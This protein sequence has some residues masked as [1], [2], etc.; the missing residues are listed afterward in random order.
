MTRDYAAISRYNEEQLGKDRKSRMSQVA[1]Y[2]DT[3]HFVYELLQN[4]DDAGATEIDFLLRPNQLIV[5]HNGTPFTEENVRAISYFGKGKTDVTAIGRFG[6]GFKSVFA[7]TATPSIHSV[8]DDFELVDL[9]TLKPAA[10]PKDL[11]S[12]RTR[13]VLPFDHPEKKPIYIEPGMLKSPVLAYGEIA[14]KLR[15]LGGATLLFTSHLR[16]I[17]WADG[18]GSGWYRRVDSPAGTHGR[19]STIRAHAAIEQHLLVFERAIVWPDE[20][21]RSVQRRPTAVAVQLDKP[22]TD[23][24]KVS[25]AENQK[26]WA[27]FPTDKETHMGLIVQGPFRTTP[28]RDN[29][30]VD[31]PFNQHLIRETA[32][33]LLSSMATL[34][35]LGVMNAEVLNRLPIKAAAY[36][37]GDF[38]RPLYEAVR[39][40]LREKKLLPTSSGTHLPATRVKLARGQRLTELFD[41]RQLSTLFGQE[42][43]EW[44]DPSVTADRY[45]AL[46]RYFTGT[47]QHQ[48]SDAWQVEPLVADIEVGIENIAAKV[49]VDF[50]DLQTDD[51]V[52][53]FYLYLHESRGL[54]YK[55]F[56]NR[57]ILRLEDG[58]HVAPLKDAT[59]QPGAYLPTEGVTDLPTVKRVIAEDPTVRVFLTEIG[60]AVPDLCDEVLTKVL[61]KYVD[62]KTH[63][64]TSWAGDLQKILAA[65]A[66]TNATKQ[67][68]LLEK[69]QSTYWV[70]CSP[71]GA[72]E[73][74]WQMPGA[75]YERSPDLLHFFTTAPETRFLAEVYPPT[76]VAYFVKVLGVAAEPRAA[77]RRADS[78]GHVILQSGH[79]YHRRGLN[80]FDPEWTIDGLQQ[81][82]ESRDLQV[83]QYI[84]N[85]IA[86]P[87]VGC[88]QGVVER[89]YRKTYEGSRREAKV[90]VAGQ[91]LRDLEWLPDR[92]GRFR[93]PSELYL[94]DLLPEFDQASR[95]AKHLS[96]ALGMKQPESA[97]AIETLARGNPRLKDLMERLTHEDLDD[98]M[99]EKLE[100]LLPKEAKLAPAGSFKDAVAAIHR[101][102]KRTSEASGATGGDPVRNPE[103]Y[104]GKL[105]EKLKEAR[106]EDNQPRAV[107]F[108]LVRERSD[109]KEARTF[110]YQEYEGRCQVSGETFTKANGQNYF[111]AVTLVPTQ[112]T[113]YLNNAGN[114]LCLS[115]DMAARFMHASFEWVDDLGQKVDAFKTEREGGTVEN[116]RVRVRLGGEE[117]VVT[118]TERHFLRLRALWQSDEQE[119]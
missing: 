27:F 95:H 92:D 1:M 61:P 57:P 102:A 17:G 81:A 114:M 71:A 101:T 51:W 86:L 119:V 110:L 84:W 36:P 83:S 30:P 96:E 59:G 65:L 112:G 47:R 26:L 104:A 80:G 55:H 10:H 98:A 31:D 38:L 7:Y 50:M 105:R 11:G 60:I 49:T 116:R 4:A 5:E 25:G 77:L 13:F 72:D 56:L 111:E 40:A 48:W 113:A 41:G 118:F 6:L 52:R 8:E 37:E 88:I 21:G 64:P 68:K 67:T 75:I 74:E 54:I 63:D 78:K 53:R 79:G 76:W 33:L 94:T 106:D 62:Q 109:T 43:L 29:V 14:G 91:L 108:R 22:L 3:A 23:G 107:T 85:R 90:S 34:R 115:A 16:E 42:G 66:G 12:G 32:A 69:L 15:R 89:A 103:R 28:A 18:I 97:Q 100:K 39:S 82:L 44:L 117:R 87:N 99:I 93:K 20:Q 2:A 35:L 70:L 24:G 58:T 19:E 46:Y 73:F 45:P 9:Y